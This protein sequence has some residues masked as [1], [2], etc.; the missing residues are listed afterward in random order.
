MGIAKRYEGMS[1]TE[2]CLQVERSRRTIKP[3]PARMR[4][5]ATE[6][7]AKNNKINMDEPKQEGE[8]ATETKKVLGWQGIPF[9]KTDFWIKGALLLLLG[10][11]AVNYFQDKKD[12]YVVVGS[13]IVPPIMYD[14]KTGQTW[15]YFRNLQNDGSILSEGWTPLPR[16]KE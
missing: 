1:E 14:K 5:A 4:E 16:P 8:S 3:S 7:A 13:G 12:R 6:E 9:L 10:V 15:R 11:T 2:L